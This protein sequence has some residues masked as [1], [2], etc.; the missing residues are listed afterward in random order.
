MPVTTQDG[1]VLLSQCVSA[2]PC[3]EFWGTHSHWSHPTAVTMTHLLGRNAFVFS[4]T[5]CKW[6]HRLLSQNPAWQLLSNIPPV[7]RTW[8]LLSQRMH[9]ALL[10]L[11]HREGSS[12]GQS[13]P[14]VGGHRSLVLRVTHRS[15]VVESRAKYESHYIKLFFRQKK[16]SCTIL[17]S[18]WR[19]RRLRCSMSFL[20]VGAISKG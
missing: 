11:V 10:L 14:N 20:R 15:E 4:R 13:S 3:F 9:S 2:K 19:G 8:A 16:N 5:S 12:W 7:T 1:C 17:C 18:H 6:V